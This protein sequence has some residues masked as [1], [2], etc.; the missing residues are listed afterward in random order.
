MPP[1]QAASLPVLPVNDEDARRRVA[2][3]IVTFVPDDAQSIAQFA[4]LGVGGILVDRSQGPSIAQFAAFSQQVRANWPQDA[5]APLLMIDQEGGSITRIADARLPTFPTNAQLGLKDAAEGE[6]AV[7]LEAEAFAEALKAGGI[8]VDLA[9]VLDVATNHNGQIISKFGRSYSAQPDRV[10]ALGAQFA[11]TLQRRGVIATLKHFPGHGM[12]TS[13]SHVQLPITDV[14]RQTLMNVHVLPFKLAWQG[15][16]QRQ[17]MIMTS[18]ILYRNLDPSNPASL[19]PRTY[20]LLRAEGY[21]GVTITDALGMKA[22]R[23]TLRSRV[24]RALH[25]GADFVLIEPG[26]EAEVPAII[27][28]VARAYGQDTRAW[29]MNRA[30]LE[31]I[32]ALKRS[33]Q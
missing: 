21:T 15:L 13:D 28:E 22:L 33:V 6:Q 27:R 26:H 18:H 5:A 17:M 3:Q 32:A 31:R 24:E 10:H 8:Q 11:A 7:R 29:E 25:A 30:A 23:G 2:Q 1:A 19:S 20:A 12:V 14:S 4:Q 16:D 9:P